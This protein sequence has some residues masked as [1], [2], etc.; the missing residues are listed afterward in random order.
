MIRVLSAAPLY[1]K[2]HMEGNY[3]KARIVTPVTDLKYIGKDF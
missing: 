2:K 3:V 1:P